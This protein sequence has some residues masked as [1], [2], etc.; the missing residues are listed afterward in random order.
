LF[1]NAFR[2]FKDLVKDFEAFFLKGAIKT[3]ESELYKPKCFAVRLAYIVIF[4]WQNIFLIIFLRS[5]L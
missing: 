3:L 1:S 5:R 2:F 4:F